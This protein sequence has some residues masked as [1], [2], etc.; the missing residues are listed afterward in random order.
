MTS[1]TSPRQCQY[2][3]L[4]KM[5]RVALLPWHHQALGH[6]GHLVPR[7]A[8]LPW[9]RHLPT[10]YPLLL[11]P[12]QRWPR[13]AMLPLVHQRLAAQIKSLGTEGHGKIAALA[14]R[15]SQQQSGVVS[16]CLPRYRYLG[17][18][19]MRPYDAR[20]ANFTYV[21]GIVPQHACIVSCL[22]LAYLSTHL[23]C[24]LA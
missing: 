24:Y 17:Q 9:H 18:E 22:L 12:S 20:Y 14:W 2:K 7:L 16:T 5:P 1:Q 4:T 3:V 15:T 8:L 11:Q 19:R 13:V 6:R 21:G 23:I 10:N